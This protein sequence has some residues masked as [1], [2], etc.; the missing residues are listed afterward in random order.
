MSP[1]HD[2]LERQAQAGDGTMMEGQDSYI[3]PNPSP[4]QPTYRENE[5]LQHQLSLQLAHALLLDSPFSYKI[6]D[7]YNFMQ[8][9]DG[10]ER[11]D[12]GRMTLEGTVVG[13]IVWSKGGEQEYSKLL[14][15]TQDRFQKKKTNVHTGME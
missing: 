15:F 4:A 6:C 10:F 7:K 12:C 8:L 5:A 9:L 11:E 3:I 2:K 13:L 1:K 14:K